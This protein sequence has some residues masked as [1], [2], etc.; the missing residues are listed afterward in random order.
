MTR[1][2]RRISSCLSDLNRSVVATL[3]VVAL[4]G[5]GDDAVAQSKPDAVEGTWGAVQ[6]DGAPKCAGTTVL[7]FHQGRYFRVLPNVG[8]TGGNNQLILSSSSYRLRGDQL[9]VA[10]ALSFTY[11]EPRRT[12]VVQRIGGRALILQGKERV[13]FK[14]CPPIDPAGLD[15]VVK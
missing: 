1:G 11:P 10:Q 8:S 13:T 3:A 14:P 6:A 15:A 5:V 12:F 7:V 4:F 2:N 9:V